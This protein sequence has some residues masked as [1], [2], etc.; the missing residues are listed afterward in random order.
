MDITHFIDKEPNR[1]EALAE[2]QKQ[3]IQSMNEDALRNIVVNFENY[4][5]LRTEDFRNAREL[6]YRQFIHEGNYD[7]NNNPIVGRIDILAVKGIREKQRRFLVDLKARVKALNLQTKEDDEGTTLIMRIHN[8][9]KQ[10]KDGYDN[11]RRHYTAYERIANPTALPQTNSFFDASTMCDDD[12]DNSIPLQK[13][14]IFTLAELEKAK[15]R[16]YKG[17]CCEERKTEEGYNTRAWEPKMTIEKFVYSLA[18]KDDNFEM[19]KNFTSKGSIFREVID[20]ISKC[21][22]NQFPDIEKR[23]HVW[24]FKNGVFVG[25][26]WEPTNPNDPEEGFYKCKFYPY[27]SNDFAVLDPTVISCKYFDQ[28]FNEFPDLERWQDIPT[29]NFDKVLQYQKFEEEVCNWAYVMGGRLCYNVGELD[30]WQIIPFFKGIAK[31]GKSTLITKVFKNFY[32]NQDVRTLSNNIEKKFGLSSI[33]DAFMFIAPEVKGDLALE[34]AEFQSLVSGENVSVAVKNKPAEEIPEWKVPGVLGGN[35]VPGWKDNSGSVLRRILPWNFSKQVRNADPRL[36]EKLKH[37][38]PN[39]LHKCI[40]AYIEYRNK[41]GDEDIWDV[42]PKY[43][44]IIKMQVAKVAN[45]LIHFLESTI[46]DKGK[47]QYVPQNLFVAA[48]NTHCKNNNLGQHKFHEDFY[49]GPFS[50]Y[51]IEVRNESVSYRGRQYPVQPVIFGID[52]IEDQLMTGN[53]H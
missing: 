22:D 2:L 51:D 7:E 5:D 24:S 29:P 44:E 19:W 37:E 30:S 35:E 53:N 49:V 15:Y 23:R 9:L 3:S 48:F 10:L 32:E 20:N 6:G 11:I 50:S 52:L 14:L 46:V 1:Y 39:I 26:E 21:N 43:F 33:K 27:D 40:R 31:S 12:L 13:C 4:W 18:N 34:Q 41:Y 42:V 16:R 8:V 38:L 36:D 45:S 28:E 47:D 25:K 17:Q